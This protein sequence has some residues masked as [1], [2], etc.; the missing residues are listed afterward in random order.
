MTH[1]LTEA[2]IAEANREVSE[3]YTTTRK[4]EGY[5]KNVFNRA[6]RNLTGGSDD[7][8]S[9]AKIVGRN[10]VTVVPAIL[11][12]AAAQIPVVGSYAKTAVSAGGELI[13]DEVVNKLDKDR[14]SELHSKEREGT[15]SVREMTEMMQKDGNLEISDDYL[16]KMHDA[17]RKLDEAYS[18]S[19]GA[20]TKANDFDSVCDAAKKYAYL[21]YRVVRL[22]YYLEIL[23]SHL[24]ELSDMN[25]RYGA[26]VIGFEADLVEMMNDFFN[27]TAPE[28]RES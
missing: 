26:Q 24:N 2:I 22:Q 7:A 3:P 13:A 1:P 27:E 25:E 17:I 19:K 8:A 14:V 10:L 28:Y 9:R 16:T 15:L 6:V 5:F 11:S 4:I 20:I 12:S 21:K 23:R 18:A